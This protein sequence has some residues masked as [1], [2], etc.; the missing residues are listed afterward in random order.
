MRIT[1]NPDYLHKICDPIS[2]KESHKVANKMHLW[3]LSN[4]NI[5]KRTLGIASNQLKLQG[6]IIVIRSDMYGSYRWLN[7]IDPMITEYSK[8]TIISQE[9]C[10]S[11]P[12]GKYGIKRSTEITLSYQVDSKGERWTQDFNGMKSFVIQHEIEH[13]NGVLISDERDD[14]LL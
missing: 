13:L 12:K 14:E 3:L 4:K 8:D 2:Y 9:T 6:R 10:L 11:V 1:T 7:Y 5:M